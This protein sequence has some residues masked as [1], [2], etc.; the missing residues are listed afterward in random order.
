MIAIRDLSS[1]HGLYYQQPENNSVNNSV[2]K[3]EIT[4]KKIKNRSYSQLL[5][6]YSQDYSQFP[7]LLTAGENER[8]EVIHSFTSF[9]SFLNPTHLFSL[10][11]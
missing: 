9:Y 10:C 2:N 3:L 4:V 7:Y 11:I 6:S 8:I 5:P 1:D